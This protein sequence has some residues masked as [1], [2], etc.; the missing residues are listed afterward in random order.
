MIKWGH[1]VLLSH[2]GRYWLRRPLRHTRLLWRWQ[3]TLRS[4]AT[5][6]ARPWLNLEATEWLEQTLQPTMRVFEWGAGG[7]TLFFAERCGQVVSVETDA[8]W[9]AVVRERLTAE[10]AARVTLIFSPPQPAVDP[11]PYGAHNPDLAGLTF[12]DAARAI[13]PYPDDWFDLV[14]VDGRARNACLRHALPKVKPGGYLLL[15]NS[16]RPAYDL[17]KTL[18]AGWPRRVFYG[19]LAYLK[20]F[21]A[22]TVW[23]RPSPQ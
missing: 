2:I 11:G 16:E 1:L 21:G 6:D 13:D 17:G 9:H 8:A 20:E 4:S 15:D 7:S 5:A 18:P 3:R 19:P 23:R 14:V 22:T 12:E 10:Q